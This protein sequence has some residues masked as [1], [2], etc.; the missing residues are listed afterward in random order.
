[1]VP[2]AWRLMSLPDDL[3]LY[4]LLVSRL[5]AAASIAVLASHEWVCSGINQPS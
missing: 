5:G 4:R 1:M 3:I 2:S